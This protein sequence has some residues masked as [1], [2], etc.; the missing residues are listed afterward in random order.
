M[1]GVMYVVPERKRP[2][3]VGKPLCESRGIRGFDHEPALAWRDG[4]ESKM[5]LSGRPTLPAVPT[6]PLNIGRLNYLWMI[7][8]SSRGPRPA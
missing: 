8:H 3:A 5:A 4:W 2:V 6:S 7:R 1:R